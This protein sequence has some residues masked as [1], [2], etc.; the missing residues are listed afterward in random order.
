M[1]KIMDEAK[2]K[3]KNSYIQTKVDVDGMCLKVSHRQDGVWYNNVE[4]VELPDSV[5]DLTNKVS[6]VKTP[7]LSSQHEGM[8]TGEG[9]SQQG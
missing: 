1:K 6:R 7:N 3:Y 2:A 5:L 8:D 9:D 4:V